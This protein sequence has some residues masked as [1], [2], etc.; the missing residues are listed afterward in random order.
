MRT[1][2][3]YLF[4]IIVI[5]IT[6]V[7]CDDS[8]SEQETPTCIENKIE[9]IKNNNVTNPPTQ[10]WKWE[11]NGNT[12]FYITSNCCDQYNF[13]YTNNCE[14]VCAP[15]GGITGNGDGN[16]PTFSTNI[17]KTLIWQDDRN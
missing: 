5:T 17:V 4:Y 8:D 12:Y 13:L 10:V 6:A 11:D 2:I 1:A 9:A 16:C 3:K 15:D 14:V 7:N